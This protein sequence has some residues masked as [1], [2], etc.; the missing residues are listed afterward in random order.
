MV[1]FMTI[2]F[3]ERWLLMHSRKKHL[4]LCA[5]SLVLGLL[6][7]VLFK[8][9]SYLNA[10]VE[11]LLGIQLGMWL[12][13]NVINHHF[14]DFLWGF[15][16]TCGLIFILGNNRRVRFLCVTISVGYGCLWELLQLF[17]IVPGTGD[18]IDI[19]TYL[20]A[21]VLAALI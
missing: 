18:I 15:S 4:Y 11:K 5:L 21:S 10:F 17:S 12:N 20:L 14:C 2:L 16:L 6:F 19:L 3:P 13:C 7:Y 1:I 9:N 8:S